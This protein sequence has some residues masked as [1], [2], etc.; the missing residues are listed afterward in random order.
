MKEETTKAALWNRVQAFSPDDPASALP[1]SARLARDQHWT[2][3]F[4][5]RV[6]EEY[7]RFAYLCIAAGHPCT[8]S[9]AVDEA[10]HLHL[11]YSRNYWE[12]FCREVLQSRLHHEPTRGGPEERTKHAD[13]YQ[14]T[15]TSYRAHFGE[16]PGDIWPS[17]ATPPTAKKTPA[18]VH[19]DTH[20]IL[21]KPACWRSENRDAA[22]LLATGGLAFAAAGCSS[23]GMTG[24]PLLDWHGP[25]FLIFYGCALPLATSYS[26]VVRRSHQNRLDAEA[27]TR[28]PPTDPY[29]LA[30][31]VGGP[32]RVVQTVIVKLAKQGSILLSGSDGK[33]LT[34]AGPLPDGA[35]R[36]EQALHAELA[37]GGPKRPLE[38]VQSLSQNPVLRELAWK[39]DSIAPGDAVPAPKGIAPLWCLLALGVMKLFI[40][41][42]RERPVLFLAFAL[43]IT[44]I[45]IVVLN[46][47]ARTPLS[48]R[49]ALVRRIQRQNS[50][51]ANQS[52]NASRLEASPSNWAMAVGLFGLGSI[53]GSPFGDYIPL[54][55]PMFHTRRTAATAGSSSGCSGTSGCSSGGDGGGGGGSGCG[56]GCGGCGGG[57]GD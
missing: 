7:K 38:L 34:I 8:P 6:V 21:R 56:S 9:P 40:G 27:A 37:A 2:R 19:S 50:H 3:T 4:A 29:E 14:R 53:V 57:G 5:L 30:A 20:W 22:V 49:Q 12:T 25:E 17:S 35:H 23:E 33:E 42:S 43:G 15:L 45:L 31:L 24:I 46:R 48:V 54:L 13:W 11:L 47:R 44:V 28:T 32:E 41:I 10:W 18:S 52:W 55:D 26:F 16:P 39:A 1:F 36:V 51:Y